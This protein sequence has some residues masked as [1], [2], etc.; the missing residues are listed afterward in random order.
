MLGYMGTF[1]QDRQPSV[2]E[3]L[4]S[5]A[6]NRPADRFILA[7]PQYPRMDLPPN[8]SHT[9][10]V[11]PRDHAAFYGSSRATLNLTRQAMRQYGWAPSTR[12]FEAAASGACI[13]SDNW[14]GLDQF[15]EPE[16]EI[17]LAEDCHDVLHHLDGLSAKRRARISAAACERVL[18]DHTYDV[19]AEQ[20]ETVLERSRIG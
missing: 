8:V 12:L 1:S 2:E 5:P 14:P 19:R 16:T 10:H 7:G 18:R 15:F 13:I 11:Y 9:T 17:L 3:L 4:I 20:F 6:R